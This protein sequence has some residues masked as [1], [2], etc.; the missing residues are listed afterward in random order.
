MKA[1]HC[2]RLLDFKNLVLGQ[3]LHY[4][5]GDILIDSYKLLELGEVVSVTYLEPSF[6]T[7]PR[8]VKVAKLLDTT[9]YIPWTNH[10]YFTLFL[11]DLELKF[12]DV[13]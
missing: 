5:G 13:I 8:N 7:G 9:K 6:Y 3:K 4:V 11:K 10:S 12:S 2:T 1:Q